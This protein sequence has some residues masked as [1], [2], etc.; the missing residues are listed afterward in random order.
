MRKAAPP[1]YIETREG[2][3]AVLVRS[4][5][6]VVLAGT[7]LFPSATKAQ[8]SWGMAVTGDGTLY[9]CDIQ[10]DRVWSYSAAGGL[11][12]LLDRNHCHTIVMGYDGRIYGENVGGESRAGN[13]VGVW[14]LEPGQKPGFLMAPTQKPDASVWVVRDAAGN[15]YAWNG[16][17][18]VRKESQIL[19]RSAQGATQVLAGSEWGFADGP[20]SQARFGDVG[21]MAAERDG[22]LYVVDSG[23]LRRIAPD[24]T[25]STLAKGLVATTYGGVPGVPGLYNHHF[26]MAVDGRGGVY[27]VDFRHHQILHWDASGTRVAYEARG[28]AN[29]AT[30]ASWGWTVTGVAVAG[31]AIYVM[32]YWPMPTPPAEL[33]GNPRIRKISAGGTVVTVMSVASFTARAA[34]GLAVGLLFLLWVARQ[35]KRPPPPIE[36]NKSSSSAACAK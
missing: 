15:S 4:A 3:V 24:G 16:N 12:M 11:S 21:A 22:T 28:L 7:L 30:H 18:E 32:E 33:I 35:W 6:W 29:W 25:V 9:F 2:R 13:A 10:R 27:T 1:P 31:D 36:S 20:G 17:R 23:D 34:V 14:E 19:K 8:T 26:G 5:T